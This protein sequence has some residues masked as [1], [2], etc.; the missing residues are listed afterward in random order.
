M[1]W[2]IIVTLVLEVPI[3]V[4]ISFFIIRKRLTTKLKKNY[5]FTRKKIEIFFTFVYRRKPTRNQIEEFYQ[6]IRKENKM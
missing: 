2:V 3:T 4:V 5:P 6:K 1:L